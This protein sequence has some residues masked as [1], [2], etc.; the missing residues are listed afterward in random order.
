MAARAFAMA[1]RCIDFE[2]GRQNAFCSLRLGAQ[3]P[4][5]LT[6]KVAVSTVAEGDVLVDGGQANVIIRLWLDV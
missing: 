6:L 4:G 5:V 1:V 3:P 2:L